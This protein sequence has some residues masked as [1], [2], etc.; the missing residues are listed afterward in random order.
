MVHYLGLLLTV[1]GLSMLFPLGWSLYHGEPTSSAFAISAAVTVGVGLIL[2]RLTPGSEGRF[3]RREAIMLVT[4]VWIMASIFGALPYHIAGVFPHY[5]DAF[6]EAMSG[7]TTT[8][9]TVLNSIETQTQSILLWRNFTQW[10]G[11]MGIITLFVALFPLFGM[12]AAHLVDAELPGPQTE[13]LT[14]RIQDTVKSLWALYVGFSLLE[15]ILLWQAGGIPKFD[16][17]SITFGTMPTGGFAATTLSI[18]A[19]TSVVVEGIVTVF[20][21]IAGINFGLH[22]LLIWKRQP[23]HLFSNPE[24]RLYIGLLIGA[25]IF[26]TLNLAHA[27]FLPAADAL[28]QGAFQT[29]SVMTTTGFSTADF[30]IWPPFSRATLLIL[31]LIGGSAGST[32][33]ALK[34]TRFM[35]LCKY[36]FRQISLAFNPKAVIPIKIGD[37]A[38]SDRVI[39]GILGMAVL[40]FSTIIVS[41]LIMSALGLDH[42]SA[43]SSVIATIGNVGPG[44]GVVGPAVDYAFIPAIG[45]VVLIICMLIGRLELL[46]V[47]SLLAPSFW[48]WR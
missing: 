39:S 40:Y 38:L 48:K 33:G 30:N 7:Y 26:I 23:K 47:F 2:W 17:L 44:L 9:A 4:G 34:V 13:K 29:V 11:G 12:G 31:M 1:L 28:R 8:G 15:F 25:T 35:V 14:A 37:S 19:Y 32:G 5:L 22:Y 18:G 36:A 46:T 24:F 21:A 16:A 41:F 20:M 43:L 45:K 27:M 42:V 10:F 6:F 3:S